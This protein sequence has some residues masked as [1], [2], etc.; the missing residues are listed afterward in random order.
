MGDNLEDLSVQIVAEFAEMSSK[1]GA[2][3]GGSNLAML[4]ENNGKVDQK[5]TEKIVI[6]NSMYHTTDSNK[7][8]YEAFQ[9]I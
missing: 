3:D 9:E 7:S 5:S 1:N 6:E 8:T 4:I 2:K